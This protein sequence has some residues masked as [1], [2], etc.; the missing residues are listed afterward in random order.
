M[1]QNGTKMRRL[2]L[3]AI[4]LTLT[5]CETAEQIT[6]PPVNVT[7]TGN[8]RIT[9]IAGYSTVT[10]RSQETNA[11]GRMVEFRGAECE[12]QGSGFRASFTTPA[13]VN[14][15]DAQSQTRPVTVTC[16]SGNRSVS[17]VAHP[18]NFDSERNLAAGEGA[19]LLGI[20]VISVVDGMRD[21][22]HDS[23]AYEDIIVGF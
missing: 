19:G 6:T 2:A 16:R 8:P 22:T 1:S 4:A 7:F 15:P 9:Q 5:A 12:M 10:V 11:D 23:F 14:M 13:V 18:Y 3:I 21:Q 17:T 20:L